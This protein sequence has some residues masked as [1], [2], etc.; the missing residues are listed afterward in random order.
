MR[1][2]Y[3]NEEINITNG[4]YGNLIYKDKDT[5]SYRYLKKLK[6]KMLKLGILC[7]DDA[8]F[9]ANYY[10]TKYP[11]IKGVFSRRFSYVFIDEMQDTMKH[12][13]NL[14][15]SLFDN[16]V[17]LQR[18][19]DQNQ[20]I[21]DLDQ[22]IGNWNVLE[23]SLSISDSKRFSPAIA[24]VVKNICVSPQN[25][26]GNLSIPDISPTIIVFNKE[27]IDKV[28]PHFGD[29]IL[30]YELNKVQNTTFK[31]IAWVAGENTKQDTLLDYWKRFS[32]ELKQRNDFDYLYSYVTQFPNEKTND[33]SVPLYRKSILCGI[34]KSLKIMNEKDENNNFFTEKSLLNFLKEKDEETYQGLLLNLADWCLSISNDKNIYEDVKE[35]IKIRLKDLFNWQD[36]DQLS[37]FFIEEKEEREITTPL[38]S[39]IFTHEKSENDIEIEFDTIHGVKGETHTATL[40]LETFYYEYDVHRILDYFKGKHKPTK[41]K[42]TLQNLKMTYVGLTRPSHL[43]CV[44]VHEETIVDHEEDLKDAGWNI[45]YVTMADEKHD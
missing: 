11:Q 31:A 19:G 24:N 33:I 40:Y 1:F 17:I 14:F 28:L 36:I 30:K 45:E 27:T 7:Y 42:R 5:A 37:T 32:K 39:N 8:Y 9:L 10:V 38:K 44:A 22:A 41:K 3:D 18:I 35:F 23:P 20:S 6:L 4:M 2:T 43:L 16:S 15:N 29:M 26:T 34:L 12:Q 25:L 13:N 21:Y